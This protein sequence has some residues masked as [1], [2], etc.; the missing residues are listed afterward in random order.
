MIG[1][2]DRELEIMEYY[3]TD[4]LMF[5]GE[6]TLDLEGQMT[7]KN[8]EVEPSKWEGKLAEVEAKDDGVYLFPKVGNTKVRILLSPERAVEDFYQPVLRLFKNRSR[9]QF[10]MPVIVFEEG[11]WGQE[12]K[13]MVVGKMVIMGILNLL[14]SGEYELLHPK[15]A[16]GI[17]VSRA[18]KGLNTTYSVMPSKNVIPVN[19]EQYVF[20]KPLLDMAKELEASDR[21]EVEEKAEEDDLPF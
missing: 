15:E 13:Y 17:I 5:D 10:M 9:T 11:E 18:G 8:Y 6:S 4:E 2:G 16:H 21:A 14:A 20:E 19:Y 3:S 1:Y 12:I 7:E